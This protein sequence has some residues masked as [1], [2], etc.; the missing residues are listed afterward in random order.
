MSGLFIAGVGCT[1]TA[2]S[3]EIVALVTA[4][5]AR[6]NIDPTD[7]VAI[8]SHSR[9]ADSRALA[10]AAHALG[11]PLRFLGDAQLDRPGVSEAVAAAAGELILTK[12]KS[13]QVTCAIARCRPGFDPLSFGQGSP[14]AAMASSTEATSWAGP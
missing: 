10:E 7:L 11:L 4:C 9:K 8:A 12:Q 1:T 14:S 13:T 6:A 3:S 5:C 2:A